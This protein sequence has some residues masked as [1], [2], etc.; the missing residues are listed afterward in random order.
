MVCVPMFIEV[1]WI[2]ALILGVQ[3]SL[4]ITFT[5]VFVKVGWI[6][7]LILGVQVSLFIAFILVLSAGVFV[8][9]MLI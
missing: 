6:S 4:F 1:G 7:A 5:L 2:S 8:A 9:L 3:V